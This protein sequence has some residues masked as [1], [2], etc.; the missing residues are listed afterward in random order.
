MHITD[1]KLG[2]L[3]DSFHIP[4]SKAMIGR[5]MGNFM[6]CS[7][8]AHAEGPLYKPS[9]CFSFGIVV[10][11]CMMVLIPYLFHPC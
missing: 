4:P 10:S 11:D 2:D 9:D 7:S 3:E 5:Q 6:W 8:E 1:V